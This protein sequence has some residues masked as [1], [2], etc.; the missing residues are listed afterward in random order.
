MDY[1]IQPRAADHPA[2]RE[3][4]SD[5]RKS[6]Y[7]RLVP[8]ADGARR[9]EHLRRQDPWYQDEHQRAYFAGV[10]IPAC[11]TSACATRRWSFH[12]DNL[13]FWLNRGVDGFRFDAV[14]VLFEERSRRLG[15]PNRRTHRCS[16]VASAGELRREVHGLRVARRPSPRRSCGS[17]FAFGLQSTSSPAPSSAACATT[18]SQQTAQTCRC[19]MATL[20]ANHD[21]FAG[22]RLALFEGDEGGY[23][24]AAATLLT[25][26]GIPF[27]YYGEEIGLGLSA[28]VPTPTS[29]CAGR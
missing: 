15:E 5:S 6:P 8:L 22:A 11:P 3:A 29:R 12:L 17:A 24:A 13:R 28:P 7:R 18:C 16:N 20:L 25:L 9:L 10:R 4:R 27:V 23:R 14:G 1:V 26:P 21:Y 19:Q 2:V